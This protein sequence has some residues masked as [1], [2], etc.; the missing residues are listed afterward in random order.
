[1][2]P[3]LPLVGLLDFFLQDYQLSENV[4]F[5]SGHGWMT[6]MIV[7][8][9]APR[10]VFPRRMLGWLTVFC[11]VRQL[12]SARE[13]LYSSLVNSPFDLVEPTAWLS[14]LLGIFCAWLLWEL[15]AS[16]SP[17]GTRRPWSRWLA[18]AV[19]ALLLA[20]GIVGGLDWAGTIE[21]FVMA[22]TGLLLAMAL[23]RHGPREEAPGLRLMA[24]G[25]G[26]F[27]LATTAS[28][29]AGA[30][31]SAWL[32]PLLH[33]VGGSGWFV[34]AGIGWA[35]LRHYRTFSGLALAF[36]L[37]LFTYPVWI[38]LTYGALLPPATARTKEQ[39]LAWGEQMSAAVPLDAVGR[40]TGGAAAAGDRPAIETGLRRI[41][42]SSA[43]VRRIYVWQPEHGRQR[44]FAGLGPGRP[45]TIRADQPTYW[46][47]LPDPA[48]L[49]AGR[50]IF[51]PPY[52]AHDGEL[53]DLSLPL[54]ARPDG[55]VVAWLTIEANSRPYWRAI[56]ASLSSDSLMSRMACWMRK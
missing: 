53:I 20:G 29:F 5:W 54:R 23:W 13:Y 8:W 28:A 49:A 21:A 51:T 55:P 52:D 34:V 42:A 40:L 24:V 46:Y 3:S 17:A 44:V 50:R 9:L 27:G 35:V 36:F 22:P 2:L 18:R 41:M 10:V 56:T 26:L 31:E 47:Q 14:R 11:L 43:F 12:I 4:Q 15:T 7:A 38:A 30:M 37:I 32:E 33:A 6:A 19:W 48:A 1:M 16:L 25:F 45:W 39:L